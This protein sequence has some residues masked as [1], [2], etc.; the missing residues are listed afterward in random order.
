MVRGPHRLGAVIRVGS[1]RVALG[2]SPYSVGGRPARPLPHFRARQNLSKVAA[3]PAMTIA[4]SHNQ[5]SVTVAVAWSASFEMRPLH[6]AAFVI[7]SGLPTSGFVTAGVMPAGGGA[8]S[9]PGSSAAA[10]AA[11]AFGLHGFGTR[12][13]FH[14]P[15]G[16]GQSATAPSGQK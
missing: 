6:R 11:S 3:M 5:P 2:E 9:V 10:G 4:A 1:G 14:A 13:S 16:F 15:G 7:A 8:S 12:W